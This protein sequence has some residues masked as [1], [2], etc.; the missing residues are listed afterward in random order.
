MAV[1]LV[2]NLAVKV[3]LNLYSQFG[4]TAKI[5]IIARIKFFFARNFK[6]KKV[7][8]LLSTHCPNWTSNKLSRLINTRRTR[9]SFYYSLPSFYQP[10]PSPSPITSRRRVSLVNLQR[11][12]L[13][14]LVYYSTIYYHNLLLERIE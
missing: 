9:Q 3:A 13:K 11:P 14:Y 4:L 10:S 8:A 2:C 7:K 1:I 12:K 5:Y 6:K